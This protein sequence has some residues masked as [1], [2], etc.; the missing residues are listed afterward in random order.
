MAEKLTKKFLMSLP[1]DVFLASNCFNRETGM[2]L[3]YEKVMA[4]WARERQWK[5]VK[6]VSANG[7]NC[8][9]FK[10]K[11]EADKWLGRIFRF[12]ESGYHGS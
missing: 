4:H 3:I 12:I 1:Q 2:P 11:E 6:E 5:K 9:V 8:H 10:T 7:R